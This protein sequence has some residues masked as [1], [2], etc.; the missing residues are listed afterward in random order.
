MYLCLIG[1]RNISAI[2]IL[3]PIIDSGSQT[4]IGNRIGQWRTGSGAFVSLLMVKSPPF[5]ATVYQIFL[6][7]ASAF[8]TGNLCSSAVN[9]SFNGSANWTCFSFTLAENVMLSES[10]I[11]ICGFGCYSIILLLRIWNKIPK[12]FDNLKLIIKG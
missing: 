4:P 6:K 9:A 3:I 8:G 5:R 1:L 7:N 11:S 10:A 12:V 2:A